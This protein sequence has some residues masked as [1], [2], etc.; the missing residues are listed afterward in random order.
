MDFAK[1][2]NDTLKDRLINTFFESGDLDVIAEAVADMLGN[3]ITVLDTSLYVM[4][5]SDATDVNDAF[6]Q[7]GI[8]RRCC[9]YEYITRIRDANLSNELGENIVFDQYDIDIY[10]R[11]LFKL[12]YA[13]KCV[14]YFNVLEARTSYDSI[15]VDRY[16]LAQRILSKTVADCLENEEDESG[17]PDDQRLLFNLLHASFTD[18]V[19]FQEF[20]SGTDLVDTTASHIVITINIKNWRVDCPLEEQL[21]SALHNSFPKAWSLMEYPWII[22]LAELA[23]DPVQEQAQLDTLRNVL[24]NYHLRAGVSDRI[25]DFFY[26]TTYY[27][28]AVSA[29]RF[30]KR[31]SDHSPL[32]SYDQY[33]YYQMLS[34][35]P[36]NWAANTYCSNVVW[37]IYE[38]DLENDTE[39]LKTLYHYL[40]AGRSVN[41]AAKALFLHRNTIS[42]RVDRIR[43]LFSVELTDT[44]E[45]FQLYHS[46]LI[47]RYQGLLAV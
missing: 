11:K 43:T 18:R 25:R 39:Y 15:P 2:T 35:L 26:F 38:Y 4:A 10:R 13:G 47:L 21:R 45:N 27:Q 8:T 12:V 16:L 46:C 42:Y 33:K 23:D 40:L 6:W 30:A 17:S 22:L 20:F 32:V 29:L 28:Q 41:T 34:D 9:P 3:P 44:Q 37:T 31:T 36:E 1:T 24:Q 19:L 14:G 5:F 7:R